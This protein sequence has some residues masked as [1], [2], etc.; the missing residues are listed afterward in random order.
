MLDRR[1]IAALLLQTPFFK[2]LPEADIEACVAAAK[3]ARFDAHEMMFARGEAG[4]RLF[5]LVSGEVRLSIVSEDGRELSVRIVGSGEILGELSAL[6][7]QTRSA[8]AVA[9]KP[10]VALALARSDLLR[11]MST[12]PQLLERIV[13]LLCGRLRTTTDQLEAVALHSVEERLARLILADI[14]ASGG[15]PNRSRVMKLTQG[16]L[17]QLIAASRP[18]VNAA[19]A[20]IEG[21]GAVRRRQG[22]IQVDLAIL[23]KLARLPD[24]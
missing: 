1:Q 13:A 12:I 18:K 7:G 21:T 4:D 3:Q 24:D 17:A 16:E 15:D 23:R 10:V 22:Q 11:L 5:I 8:D 2:G 6:D 14:A 19:L 20:S 9:M